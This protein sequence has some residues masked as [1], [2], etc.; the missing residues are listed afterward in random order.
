M[1]PI[2]IADES[3]FVGI[4]KVIAANNASKKDVYKFPD[5]F[6][7]QGDIFP[8]KNHIIFVIREHEEITAFL[9]LH[10]EDLNRIRTAQFEIIVHPEYRDREKHRGENLLKHVIDYT[11]KETKIILLI[12]KVSKDNEPSVRLLHKCGFSCD[13]DNIVRLGYEMNL[14]IQRQQPI[15]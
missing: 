8:P 9:S 10:N 4:K 13:N 11:K 12:A 6:G 15:L 3:D 14:R 1:S 2:K 5:Y 7:N